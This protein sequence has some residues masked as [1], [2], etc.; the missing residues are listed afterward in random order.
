MK[1]RFLGSLYLVIG[2]LIKV[3][4]QHQ[5][6]HVTADTV[7]K[8]PLFQAILILNTTN[9]NSCHVP[10]YKILDYFKTN[11]I[12]IY[13]AHNGE[14][15]PLALSIFNRQNSI[16]TNDVR[17]ISMN[18]IYRVTGKKISLNENVVVLMKGKKIIYKTALH[19]LNFNKLDKIIEKHRF[20]VITYQ[21]IK[22]SNKYHKN[23]FEK[24]ENIVYQ[25]GV[26]AGVVSDISYL[27]SYDC[28]NNLLKEKILSEDTSRYFSICRKILNPHAQR[29]NRK[30]I[31]DELRLK[32]PPLSLGIFAYSNSLTNYYLINTLNYYA[33]TLFR[34]RP[35]TLSKE[36]GYIV[37]LDTLFNGL[38]TLLFAENYY[39][40]PNVGGYVLNDTTFFFIRYSINLSKYVLSQFKLKNNLLFLE[41]DI[42]IP[43][44]SKDSESIIPR[45]KLLNTNEL[46][47]FF[48]PT[49]IL[50]FTHTK[51]LRFNLIT[52]QFDL[53]LYK[54]NAFI[55]YTMFYKINETN[56]LYLVN[57]KR[58]LK[59]EQYNS[60]SRKYCK[61]FNLK[62][63]L[64]NTNGSYTNSAD[65]YF[66][67]LQD[68]IIL[69]LSVSKKIP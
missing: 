57:K 17:L 30:I 54:K 43:Y 63:L 55:S 12:I 15:T 48:Y 52:N 5:N 62:Q 22:F 25:N 40:L 26:I 6:Y 27:F 61:L 23:I 42:H 16:D 36:I 45:M 66:F 60:V 8:S 21:V 2:F 1:M 38:D 32:K 9:C 33:D 35:A 14:M 3:S 53:L 39:I 59:I 47:L 18:D 41:K 29:Q 49:N 44:H 37:K 65:S 34:N 50:K 13:I 19:K 11:N 31:N 58:N 4:A 46:A 28:K 24:S 69:K 68:N 56:Y 10:I 51:I 64:L 7:Q 20:S 67:F